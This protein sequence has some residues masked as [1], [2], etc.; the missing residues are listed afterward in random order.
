[1][2]AQ[3]DVRSSNGATRWQGKEWDYHYYMAFFDSSPYAICRLPWYCTPGCL[4][5]L[6]F[7]LTAA[8]KS[9]PL[10]LWGT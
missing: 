8:E 3:P 5:I 10:Q 6:Q 1:M 2:H 4:A 7:S 9:D